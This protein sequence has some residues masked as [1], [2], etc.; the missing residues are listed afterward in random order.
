MKTVFCGP[1]HSGKS[2]FIVN[3][4][5][6]LPTDTFTIVRACPDG[7]GNWSNNKNQ[8]ETSAVRKKGK[9]TKTFIADKCKEIDNQTNKIVLVDVGGVMSPENEQIFKHCDNFVVLSSDE[10]Q[11]QK[12]LEFGQKLGL[13]CIGC[14]DSTLDGHEEIYSRTPYLQGRI[15]GLERGSVLVDSQVIKALV[16]DIIEKSKYAERDVQNI[17]NPDEILIDDTELGFKLGYGNEIPTESGTLIKNVRWAEDAIPKVYHDIRNRLQ[18][19]KPVKMN[20]IR[21]NFIFGTICNVC[22]KSGVKDLSCFDIRSKQYIQIKNFPQKRN[23]QS[24]E[25][26]EYHL[27]ENNNSVF[28][29]VDITK[30]QFSLEDYQ[31]CVLPKINTDKSLYLS[32]R[33]PLWLLGSIITSYDSDKI[34]TFQPGKGFTCVS[35]IYENEL[36]TIVDGVS[37][38]NL[39]KYFDD[40]KEMAANNKHPVLAQNQGVFSKIKRFWNSLKDVLHLILSI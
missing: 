25:G 4:I 34:F 1:P 2:V 3:L 33:M 29:D 23:I 35:S 39:S 26:L 8:N 31:K 38:I 7:E 18:S 32:G 27:I 15:V 11:K 36:G 5:Y 30:E 40:K 19:D 12:W 16:S 9:F 37:G 28:M 22:K 20:G 21:A 6:N 24:S 14:L 17:Q 13:E 10:R